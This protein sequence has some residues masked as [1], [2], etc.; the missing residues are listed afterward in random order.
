MD[1]PKTGRFAKYIHF[2]VSDDLHAK[3]KAEATRRSLSVANLVRDLLS[4]ALA[5]QAAV[6][7]RDALDRAIRRAIKPDVERLAKMLAKATV[8]GATAMYLNTQALADL[9][10][11][12]AMELYHAAR[13]KAVA[14]LRE[15]GGDG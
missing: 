2:G 12:D 3:L 14:Y 1:L 8:A 4:Q 10:K 11:H 13:K 6:E 15:P 5:E 7:G 9:G